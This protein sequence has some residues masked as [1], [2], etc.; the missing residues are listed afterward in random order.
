MRRSVQLQSI[1]E[2]RRTHRAVSQ[3][4]SPTAWLQQHPSKSQW[5]AMLSRC[6]NPNNETYKRYGARGINCCERW[7]VFTNFLA[8]MGEPPSDLHSLDRI[9]NT[10]GYLPENCR[11]ATPKEQVDNSSRPRLLTLNGETHNVREW[12]KIIG[13]SQPT[14]TGRLKTWTLEH[15]LSAPK[16]T[17]WSRRAPNR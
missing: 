10:K 13:I 15:A 7:Y 17:K 1:D 12:A 11:W 2:N 9:D 14:L 6:R 3:H 16:S 8:D 4:S 5:R